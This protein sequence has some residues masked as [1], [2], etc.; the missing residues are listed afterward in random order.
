MKRERTKT[1]A[2]GRAVIVTTFTI[3][4]LLTSL[5]MPSWAQLWRPAWVALVLIYWCLAVPGRVGVLIGWSIGLA[6]DAMSGT[7]LGQHALALAA[8]AFVSQNSHHWVRA[9]PLAQQCLC[10]FGLVC[11]YQLLVSWIST[12]QGLAVAPLAYFAPA[13]ISML[14]WPWVFV[15]LRD[16]RR[17]YHIA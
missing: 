7:L 8:V 2:T 17:K 11:A 1:P 16:V 4:L 5:P 6:L 9:L 15:L 12:M 3:A 14:L 10:V 13:V